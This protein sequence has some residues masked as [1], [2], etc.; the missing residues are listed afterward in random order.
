MVQPL[1]EAKRAEA[2]L[3]ARCEITRMDPLVVTRDNLF[4]ATLRVAL[5]GDVSIISTF[6][7]VHFDHLR[8]SP[9]STTVNHLRPVDRAF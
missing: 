8:F 7:D 3:M 5:V 1:K 4:A 2:N 6:N 9:G